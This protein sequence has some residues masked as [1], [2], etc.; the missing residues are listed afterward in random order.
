MAIVDGEFV[1]LGRLVKENG[2]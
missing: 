1:V 2:K